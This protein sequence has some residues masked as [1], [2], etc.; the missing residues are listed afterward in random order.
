MIDCYVPT[1]LSSSYPQCENAQGLFTTIYKFLK[2]LETLGITTEVAR[3]GGLAGTASNVNYWDEMDPF[4]TN[5]WFVF[6]FNPNGGRTWPW[7]LHFQWSGAYAMQATQDFGKSPGQPGLANAAVPYVSANSHVCSQAAI[8]VGGDEDPWNGIGS[9]GTNQKGGRLSGSG[10]AGPVWT[11][12][13]GGSDVLVFPRS[14][15]TG[16]THA[17]TKQNYTVHWAATGSNLVNRVHL[18]ADDD[19]FLFLYDR[20]DNGAYYAYYYGLFTP[21]P[22]ITMTYP[23][24]ATSWEATGTDVGPIA[25]TTP[26]GGVS[27]ASG[28]VR[29]VDLSRM[30][31]FQDEWQ[32]YPNRF[33]PPNVS[34]H[35]VWRNQLS[36]PEAGHIGTVGEIDFW[37]EVTNVVPFATNSARTKLVLG[38]ATIQ[39][40]KLLV[41]WDG[42]TPPRRNNTIRTG[43]TF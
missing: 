14:N 5:A 18:L 4:K 1:V 37:R 40:R 42:S 39:T 12:P 15:Y 34:Q 16:G 9:M 28:G 24:V 19:N 32:L 23:F 31:L 8:G 35:D 22:G 10:G 3:H 43:T 21:L 13:S 7:Y 2:H 11:I 17:T 41:P 33:I 6:R 38:S 20:G 26:G 29:I 27:A 36:I 30:V 25:G